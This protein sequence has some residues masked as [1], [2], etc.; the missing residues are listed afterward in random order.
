M[1][2][3]KRETFKIK[4]ETHPVSQ[5]AKDNL[6]YFNSLKKKILESMGE[7]ELSI[8]QIAERIEMSRAE[9][10]YYVMTLLKF[11]LIQVL[12]IDDMDEYYIYRVKK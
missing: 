5:Q 4:R 9:T 7:E 8:P 6:K 1:E 11:G 3:K 2:E 10:L 12:R